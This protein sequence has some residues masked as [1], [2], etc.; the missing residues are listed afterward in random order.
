MEKK[1]ALPGKGVSQQANALK[2]VPPTGKN[3]AKFYSKK[4]KSGFS[5]RN[6]YWDKHALF[7]LWGILVIKASKLQSGDLGMIMMVVFWVIA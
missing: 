2:I 7:F 3:C 5:D 6:Q 4:E 1:T